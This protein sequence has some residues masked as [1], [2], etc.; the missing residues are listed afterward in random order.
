MK[1]I[2]INK[3]IFLPIFIG[4]ILIISGFT[5]FFHIARA[6]EEEPTYIDYTQQAQAQN[7]G[8]AA[9]ANNQVSEPE[10][11]LSS[12][13]LAG[14]I[15]K[16]FFRYLGTV[17]IFLATLILNT[18]INLFEVILREGFN[19]RPA[20][21]NT[22][23]TVTR[24]I[25]NMFFILIMV[26]IA[27]ATIL[28]FE[29]YGVKQLLPKLIF[30]A[31]LINF[32]MI[33]CFVLIDITNLSA[34]FFISN[35]QSLNGQQVP[36]SQIFLDGL[37]VTRSYTTS[38]CESH[39][40]D[41]EDCENYNFT[42]TELSTCQTIA[43]NKFDECKKTMET[44][45]KKE[46][47]DESVIHVIVSQMGSAAVLFIAAFIFWAGALIMVIRMVI[48]WFL[49]IIAPLAFILGI[50]PVLS[51][52]WK[53]WLEQFTR[54]CLFAPVFAFFIW[55]ASR[56]CAQGILEQI[57]ALQNNTLVTRGTNVSQ[58]FSDVKYIYNFIFVAAFL[59]GGL[60]AANKMGIAGASAAMSVG[61][62]WTNSAK[63]WAKKQTVDRGAKV[64]KETGQMYGGA[65]RQVGGKILQ[66]FPGFK[67]VGARME[68]KGKT[69]WQKPMETKEM[70]AY[71]KELSTMSE[72]Q[73]ALLI[74]NPLTSS[75][76]KLAIAQVGMEKKDK[77][78]KDPEYAKAASNAF[79][80]FGMKKESTEIR[81]RNPNIETDTTK[82][83][84]LAKEGRDRGY[85]KEYDKEVFIGESGKALAQDVVEISATI[86]EF[87]KAFK[88]LPREAQEEWKNAAKQNFTD[89][90][91][92]MANVKIRQ[93]YAAATG[94]ATP[95][96][97]NSA[98]GIM[99]GNL[100]VFVENMKPT[101][102]SEIDDASIAEVSKH[103]TASMA[104]EIGKFLS[105]AMKEKYG[106]EFKKDPTK[107]AELLNNAGWKSYVA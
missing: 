46:K 50:L 24:D 17:L 53:G 98:G 102:F 36:L 51:K 73:R 2:K 97:T 52:H 101:D 39:L 40:M 95:A 49:V 26:V 12:G 45:A 6:Q 7:A 84:A 9:P 56:I 5:I 44:A 58:F 77:F 63:G 105:G 66:K 92:D 86:G 99:S 76:K 47:E 19:G 11:D 87:V 91:T 23:W 21:V 13:G 15:A 57:S 89:D 54:W 96:F 43:Q 79:Q 100:K 18:G 70:Q 37:Q 55:L 80:A 69:T 34:N 14:W 38:F 4:V 10:K 106:N 82:R 42:P 60:I 90:P 65:A 41:R 67:G 74:K 61:K 81:R 62:K 59:L 48:V 88:E 1:K 33:L 75:A 8:P 68:A 104:V 32:S 31:L 20:I 93:A 29:R 27:F 83:R 71:K 85:H 28:R 30:V 3:K 78:S 16:H 35:A 72:S 64:I 107:Q 94:E 25:A 103:V 22:G